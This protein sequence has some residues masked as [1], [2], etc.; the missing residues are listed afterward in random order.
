MELE[1]AITAL[2]QSSAASMEK[3]FAAIPLNRAPAT[4]PASPHV[5][6]RDSANQCSKCNII[7]HNLRASSG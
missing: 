2:L 7:D 5:R 6:K 3:M 4:M 1:A